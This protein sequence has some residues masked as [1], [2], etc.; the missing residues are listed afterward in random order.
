MPG[1]DGSKADSRLTIAILGGG[2]SG[3]TLA[4]QILRRSE[5]NVSVVLVERETRLGRGVAY[6]TQCVDHL[7]NVPASNMSAYAEDPQHFLRWAC[8]HYGP[9]VNDRAVSP[10]AFL[11]RS[12]YGQY[13]TYVLQQEVELRPNQFEHRQDE[14]ISVSRAGNRAKIQFR[15]GQFLLAD[16]VV[17]A[18]GNFPPGDPRLPGKTPDSHRYVSNPWAARS[19]DGIGDDKSVLLIGSGLTSV[20]V[21]IALRRRGFTGTV[22]ML[23]RRGLL[24]QTHKATSSGAPIWDQGFPRTI[25]GLLRSIRLRVQAAERSGSD[26]RAVIDSL[27]PFV[28]E[29]WQSLPRQ[30]Q[31]RFLRH[32]RP[33]WDVHRHRVAPE[34]GDRLLN[35]LT[36]GQTQIHAGRITSYSEQPDG[37]VVTYRD[38]ATGQ[39]KLLQVDRVVNCTG[40]ESDCRKVND[41]LLKSLIQQ[42]LACSDALFLGLN[43]SADGAL[44][45]HSGVPSDLLDA[46]GPVRKGSLWE[47]IAVP[48]IRG[49]VSELSKLLL[50]INADQDAEGPRRD[51][52]ADLCS[53]VP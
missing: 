46:V 15:S 23:S 44:I 28:Q 3:A 32:V 9:A 11:P 41:P 48:E 19:L 8:H 7:L 16:K 40:P 21:G 35:E 31:R 38:R 17:L 33:F 53:A 25:R 52:V 20:D 26:W 24:P 27:R 34:I 6:G 2:F 13:V 22:H 18:L 4:A 36:T 12:V 51:P 50:T 10:D 29:I 47:T 45:D 37:V 30:E 14:A 43:V 39:P 49:Q 1:T 42:K 5:G